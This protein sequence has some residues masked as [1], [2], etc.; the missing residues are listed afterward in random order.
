MSPMSCV[1]P[2]GGTVVPV[3]V[4]RRVGGAGDQPCVVHHPDL[5]RGDISPQESSLGHACGLVPSV[6][7]Q[8]GGPSGAIPGPLACQIGDRQRGLG[9]TS[10]IPI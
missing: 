10:S 8:P 6:P 3:A 5:S 9:T 2:A 7:S 4:P 1:S